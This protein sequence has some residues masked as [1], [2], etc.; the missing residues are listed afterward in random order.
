MTLWAWARRRDFARLPIPAERFVEVAADARVLAH[1][2][3][4]RDAAAHPTLI[5]LHGL[6][7]SSS[8]HYM[9][10]VARKAG[11]RGSTSRCSTSGTAA[12]PSTCRRRSITPASRPT[13]T[14][15]SGSSRPKGTGRSSWPAIRWAAISRSS[16]LATTA[17][18]R[19]R[20]S[21]AFAVSPVMDLAPLR[22]R[23]RAEEQPD[24]PVEL[25][26]EPEG[27]HAAEGSGI[28]GVVLD[29]SAGADSDRPAVRRGVHRPV[30][31]LPER[32]RLLLSRRGPA[33]GRSD[34]GAGAD[35][36][37]RRRSVRPGRRVPA[38]ARHGESADQRRALCARRPLRVRRAGRRERL[39]RVLGRTAHRRVRDVGLRISM[40]SQ[41]GTSLPLQPQD[42]AQAATAR[43]GPSTAARTR[44]P[45]PLPRA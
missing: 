14:S 16:W 36:H 10:G 29:R 5:V 18:R 28:P 45:S 11:R 41:G 31:R 20:R 23:A 6:E 30:L 17:R 1:C 38:A 12:A 7:G 42:F 27:A 34:L 15:C 9:R 13:S 32:D 40:A 44:G 3:F 22:G 43:A 8:A 35:R 2:Y 24:L 21:A 4:H 33:S 26:A 39:R 19:R 37:G 25:R